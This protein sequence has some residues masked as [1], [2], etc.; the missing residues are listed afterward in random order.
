MPRPVARSPRARAG[1]GRTRGGTNQSHGAHHRPAFIRGVDEPGAQVRSAPPGSAG[2]AKLSA[3]IGRPFLD[4]PG[5]MG[6]HAIEHIAEVIP[7][8]K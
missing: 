4:T 8:A 1:P 2:L 5:Q 3:T 6:A 7:A